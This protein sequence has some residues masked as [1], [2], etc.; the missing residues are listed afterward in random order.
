[1]TGNYG[2]IKGKFY[3]WFILNRTPYWNEF[4]SQFTDKTPSSYTVK[5]KTM[6]GTI[7]HFDSDNAK[8]T[9]IKPIIYGD[10]LLGAVRV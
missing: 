2:T 6:C 1:M 4:G 9:M 7:V 10:T 5:T 8:A 3:D